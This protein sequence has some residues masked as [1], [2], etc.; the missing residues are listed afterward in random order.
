[1]IC[2]A[3]TRLFPDFLLNTLGYF[4]DARVA[5]VQ[6]PHWFY[7]IPEPG[8]RASFRQWL[9]GRADPFQA[10]PGLFFDIIQRRRNR[11]GASFCCGAGSLHRTEA[12]FEAALATRKDAGRSGSQA[13][14]L[15]PFCYHVSEDILTSI[16][17]HGASP[18]RW[19]SVYHP[20]IEC[21]MLSPWS[22]RAW[23]GQKLKYAG[24]TFDIMLRH[25]PLMRRAMP[26]RIRL[27]YLATFSSYLSIIWVLAL[28]LA[29]IVTLVT[30]IAPVSAYSTEF[31]MRLIPLLLVNELALIVGCWGHDPTYGTRQNLAAL[32]INLCALL[33]GSEGA[34]DPFCPDTENPRRDRVAPPL[35]AASGPDRRRICRR[36]LGRASP[37]ALARHAGCNAGSGQ[38]ILDRLEQLCAGRPDPCRILAPA[39]R[40][41]CLH[42]S[43][44]RG[45]TPCARNT[46]QT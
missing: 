8:G 43:C 1:M 23:A 46:C 4:C 29:P 26:W 3:D 18:W 44:D 31:F 20:R 2:D 35:P 17:L 33:A 39:T 40:G 10:D 19:R 9:S 38:Y 24:G 15:R 25:N 32:Q 34:R 36:E 12:L 7:D 28:L 45:V 6:T 30:G 16:R 14:D 21:R 13:G 42:C 41:G 37:L 22:L 5:W 27:H 11:N